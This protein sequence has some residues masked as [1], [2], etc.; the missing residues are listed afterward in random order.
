M[1]KTPLASSGS[2]FLTFLP[3][4]CVNRDEL[5]PFLVCKQTYTDQPPRL[6]SPLVVVAFIF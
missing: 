2:G 1:L 4:L 6:A 5:D 3:L